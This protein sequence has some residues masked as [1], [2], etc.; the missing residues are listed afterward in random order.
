M[1]EQTAQVTTYPYGASLPAVKLRHPTTDV[2]IAAAA[3]SPEVTANSGIYNCVFDEDALL[4]GT[5]RLRSVISGLPLNRWVTFAGIADEIVIASE[6][7][8]TPT[9]PA[10]QSRL[11]DIH[12]IVQ[13]LQ[14]PRSRVSQA[15]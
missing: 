4:V 3:E 1:A 13:T 6:S 15:Y 10:V 9:D 8:P 11:D 2:E 7:Y 5:Y 12:A 14:A